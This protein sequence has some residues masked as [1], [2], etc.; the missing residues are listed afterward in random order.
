ESARAPRESARRARSSRIAPVIGSSSADSWIPSSASWRVGFAQEPLCR[1][2][3]D[4]RLA[5]VDAGRA[6]VRHRL[7]QILL[8]LEHLEIGRAP[9]LA[10]IL[11]GLEL[12]PRELE[13]LRRGADGLGLVVH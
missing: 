7:G 8:E 4:E 11:S 3:C 5:E 1:L 13:T 6:L 12:A 2:Q 10:S 9:D